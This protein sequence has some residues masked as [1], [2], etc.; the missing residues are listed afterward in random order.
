MEL[1]DV[2]SISGNERQLADAVEICLQG[3]A[4]LEVSRLGNTVIARTNL[5]RASRVIVAGHLDTVPA[6]GNEGAMLIQAGK[7]LPH[8]GSLAE[9]DLVFGL[10]ACDMKGGVAVALR[11]AVTLENP[12]FDVTY[13]F[14]E[15]EEV[16]SARNG[17]TILAAQQPDLLKADVAVLLEPSN[18][19]IEAGCQGTL[20][21]HIRTK[22]I[23]SHSARSWLGDNAIHHL[24]EVLRRL[25][26]YEPAR[27]VIDGLEYREGLNA[28]GISGGIAGNVLPDE[29][30]VEVNY[31]YAP[32]TSAEQAASH[33]AEVFEG[34]EVVVV[35]NAGGALPGLTQDALAELVRLVDGQVAP[36]FGWTDVARFAAMGIPA[37]NLGPGDP[38]LAHSRGE[39][40]TC[41]QLHKCEATM[42]TWLAG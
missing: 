13:I 32:S 12:Q 18:A 24:G 6:A 20:R 21:A 25:N 15:C 4:W 17:L 11:A 28:V 27:V 38:G 10:G 7:P 37:V 22:G 2:A 9:E 19:Q 14:Y 1:V 40:V 8:D 42:Y 33:M 26:D 41:A 5:G 3:C 31:R 23:R 39:F 30:M 35:D 29:A 36:K 16:D 34:F